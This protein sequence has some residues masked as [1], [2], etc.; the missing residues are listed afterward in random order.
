MVDAL[1][2]IGGIL[3]GTG[4]VPCDNDVTADCTAVADTA[5]TA[6]GADT[7]VFPTLPPLLEVL[8]G[9]GA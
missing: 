6:G 5:T 2:G 3:G 7:T 1:T 8:D 9:V 4:T